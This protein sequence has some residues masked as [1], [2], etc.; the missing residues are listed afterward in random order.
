MVRGALLVLVIAASCN[1]APPVPPNPVC[2]VPCTAVV[3][4]HTGTTR[5]DL[6]VVTGC[7]DTGFAPDGTP[8]GD[9]VC[10]SGQCDFTQC[11]PHA[12]CTP[13]MDE[14]WDGSTVCPSRTCIAVQARPDGTPCGAGAGTCSSGSCIAHQDITGAFTTTYVKDDLSKTVVATPPP[15]GTSIFA[16]VGTTNYPGTIAQDGSFAI[17]QLPMLNYWLCTSYSGLQSCVEHVANIVG[18]NT[19]VAARSDLKLVSKPTPVTV[20]L[21]NLDPF[22]N[23][24]MLQVTSAQGGVNLR[25]FQLGGAAQ[26]ANGVTSASVVVDWS[27]GEVGNLNAGLP[28]A[29]KQDT[30]WVTMA[31]P[32]SAGVG[33]A[34][35]KLSVASQYAKLKDWTVVDGVSSSENV[36]LMS[37]AQT[38]NAKLDI[39]YSQFAG[40]TATVNPK[41]IPTNFYADVLAHADSITYPGET[42]GRDSIMLLGLS[43]DLTAGTGGDGG[44]V[45]ADYDYG[46]L[47]YG[48]F[49]DANWKEF[50]YAAFELA[51]TF[52]AP[53]A[54]PA[55]WLGVLSSSRPGAFKAPIAPALGPPQ[56]PRINNQDGFSPQTAVTFNPTI[57]WNAPTL[58]KAT[59]YR[60]TIV[61]VGA[62]NGATVLTPVFDVTLYL[63]S[64]FQIPSG[65]LVKGANYF[66]DIVAKAA[67]W[68]VMDSGGNGVPLDTADC[69]TATFSP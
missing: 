36:P 61:R 64:S 3:S 69:I 4:C 67:P 65:V 9:G 38:G 42:T 40:L 21:A 54:T 66:A 49:L 33:G 41:A 11:V 6:G 34:T 19:S 60:V 7:V 31:P 16:L 26:P 57:S 28:D 37:A 55:T 27:K 29:S 10:I 32:R 68:D 47:L 62:V 35:A 24:T 53:N 59:S 43:K 50:S 20:N 58:G 25:P 14:C 1:T 13:P 30:V 56:L 12:A 63:N 18:L 39:R 44:V 23:D 52:T 5:C 8:C 48:Q 2:D 22:A 15:Q 46:S 51:V 45:F 17:M